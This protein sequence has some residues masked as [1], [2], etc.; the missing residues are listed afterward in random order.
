MIIYGYVDKIEFYGVWYKRI[1]IFIQVL[2]YITIYDII[3]L[4]LCAAYY[5]YYNITFSP[6][7]PAHKPLPWRISLS[8]A[9]FSFWPKTFAFR[10]RLDSSSS[11][12][13]RDNCNSSFSF[14]LPVCLVP[15]KMVNE[16]W[17]A[18]HS[19]VCTIR[20]GRSTDW[21]DH[22]LHLSGCVRYGWHPLIAAR[23]R[24]M[25]CCL[26]PAKGN[27]LKLPNTKNQVN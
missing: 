4:Y 14:Y 22:D 12:S 13:R 6:C 21:H 2:P 8:Q 5:A 26:V 25:M 19:E 16:K 27:A 17:I 10:G 20:I 7:V 15:F 18:G 1:Y 24:K 9:L 23:L 11:S 3:I